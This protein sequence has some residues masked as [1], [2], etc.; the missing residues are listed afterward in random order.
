MKKL[1]TSLLVVMLVLTSVCALADWPERSIELIVPANPGGDTDA[2]ARALA[3]A[4]NEQ[5]GWNV[6]VS[7]MSGASGAVAHEDVLANP[8]DGYR[9]VFYHSGAP[10]SELMGM[11]DFSLVDDFKFAGMPFMDYSSAF[12]SNSKNE[13]FSDVA[14]MVAYMKDHPEEI[15]FATETG[16]FTHLHA[17]AFEAAADVKFG[18]VDAGTAAQKITELLGQRL[19]VIDTQAGLVRDYLDTGDFT[20]LGIMAEE[21]LEGRPEIPTLKEQGYDVVFPK[22]FYLATA[23]SV[24]DSVIEAMNAGLAQVVDNEG[25]KTYANNA[26]VEITSMSPADTAAF[27]QEQSEVYAGYLADYIE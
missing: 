27:Y 5:L 9:F 24:D 18:I 22:F 13:K 4:L 8:D 25:L 7:N 10:I 11:Y 21:R 14:S 23:K 15:T 17:L 16:N 19:D 2:N 26:L 20:C 1:L 3:A 6:I 12:L